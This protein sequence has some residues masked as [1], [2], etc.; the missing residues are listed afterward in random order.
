MK[1]Q[2]G[3][4]LLLLTINGSLCFN[5]DTS[6]FIRHDGP[7]KSMFGFSVALHQEQQRSW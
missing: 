1:S 2:I 5:L 3:L 6:N 7:D 4:L